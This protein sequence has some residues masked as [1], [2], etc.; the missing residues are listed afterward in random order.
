MPTESSPRAGSFRTFAITILGITLALVPLALWV[1]WSPFVFLLVLA[2]CAASL[3]LIVVLLGGR[4]VSTE[5]RDDSVRGRDQH[6]V[7]DEF[8]AEVHRIFPFTHHHRRTGTARF[9]G[10]MEKLRRLID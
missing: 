4:R 10:A 8:V 1:A 7:S 3:A 6:T 2:V 9:R 5:D